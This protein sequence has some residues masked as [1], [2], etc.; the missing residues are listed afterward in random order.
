MLG[1]CRSEPPAEPPVE[2]EVRRVLLEAAFGNRYGDS[3][4]RLL[5]WGGPVRVGVT[6]DAG[7][8]DRGCLRRAVRRIDE[9][10]DALPVRLDP[11]G[12][13]LMVQYGPLD[14]IPG[15]PAESAADAGWVEW[16]VSAD[17][18]IRSARVWVP[19][20]DSFPQYMRDNLALEGLMAALGL[21]GV[22]GDHYPSA[23]HGPP[24]WD[25][26]ALAPIDIA[27]LGLLYSP[28]LRPGM[29]REQVEDAL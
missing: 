8:D 24:N 11:E 2:E 15:E 18:T 27:T 19:S 9:A 21:P 1:G 7:Y 10:L 3:H 4:G 13:E 22:I 16:Q 14:A 17:G 23:L 20:D 26:V 28:R 6:G 12:A 5:R 25:V 29:R